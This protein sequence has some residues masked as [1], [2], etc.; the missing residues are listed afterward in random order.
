ML[1]DS[2]G[3]VEGLVSNPGIRSDIFSG[4]MQFEKEASNVHDT[5]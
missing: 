4:A 3:R 2:L 5:T 1:K